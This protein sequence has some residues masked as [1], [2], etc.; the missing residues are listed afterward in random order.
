[1]FIAIDLVNSPNI[2]FAF[3]I[4]NILLAILPSKLFYFLKTPGRLETYLKIWLVNFTFG[5]IWLIGGLLIGNFL[6]SVRLFLFY[7]IIPIS[8][9]FF[10]RAKENYLDRTIYFIALV[11]SI[12]CI[13]QFFVSNVFPG[14]PFGIE[15]VRP[16]LMSIIPSDQLEIFARIGH[17]YRS[18]GIT[19]NYH[20]SA[21]ILV[22]VIVYILGKI[23]YK[24][25][26]ALSLI[27]CLISI[28]GLFTTLSLANI[29]VCLFSVSILS[30]YSLQGLFKRTFII[31]LFSLGVVYIFTINLETNSFEEVFNQLN[32]SG[33]KMEAM[34]SFGNSS[35]STS[36]FSLLFGHGRSNKFSDL[37][38]LSESALIVM[39]TEFGIFNFITYMMLLCYPLYLFY[40]SNKELRSRMFVPLTV[41]IS[42]LLTL[43]HYGSLFRSTSIFLF[44]AFYSIVIKE[45]LVYGEKR[46]SSRYT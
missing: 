38:Q 17:L 45:Y 23:F 33:S 18:H 3:T 15:I 24:N 46:G 8:V 28:I 34:M 32:P 9:L 7:F 37:G 43:S 5:L 4:F 2:F 25:S 10:I 13:I 12:S 11:V 35:F 29:I 14:D 20:D 40:I 41:V 39:L 21:N 36:L 27:I 42:G 31:T 44:F 26:N 1:M 19:G 6:E 16:Y 22:L 30:L